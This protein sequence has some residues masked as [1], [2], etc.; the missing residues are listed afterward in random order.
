MPI[1]TEN[2]PKDHIMEKEPF[3]INLNINL[4]I[5]NLIKTLNNMNNKKKSMKKLVK[6]NKIKSFMNLKI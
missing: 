4:N 1:K 5:N 3:K 2:I 6:L